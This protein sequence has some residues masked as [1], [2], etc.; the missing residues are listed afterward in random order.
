M[1]GVHM[2]CIA[3]ASTVTTVLI[4]RNPPTPGAIPHVLPA[5]TISEPAPSGGYAA[6]SYAGTSR[7]CCPSF[8]A[9]GVLP[10]QLRFANAGVL[11]DTEQRSHRRTTCAGGNRVFLTAS[12]DEIP[13]QLCLNCVSK[14]HWIFFSFVFS[15]YRVCFPIPSVTVDCVVVS[16]AQ[17][18]YRNKWVLLILPNLFFADL[19]NF[20]K[21]A[22]SSIFSLSSSRYFYGREE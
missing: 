21:A 13:D 8:G 10:L 2:R 22:A 4:G 12:I 16:S 20:S 11:A 15:K 5:G 1:A 17:L 14:G 19:R 7:Q 9:A 6:A 18:Y 3:W